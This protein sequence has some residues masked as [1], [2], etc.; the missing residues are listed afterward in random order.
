MQIPP[1]LGFYAKLFVINSLSAANVYLAIQAIVCSVISCVR[2]LNIIQVSSKKKG[3]IIALN[4]KGAPIKIKINSIKASIISILTF[5][6]TF[7]FINPIYIISTIS[8]L[9]V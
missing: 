7:S 8:K 5:I 9:M 2:Y 1:F 6:L 3:N 4:R